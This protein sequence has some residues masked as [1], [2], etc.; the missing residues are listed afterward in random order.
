[1]SAHVVLFAFLLEPL[2]RP[3]L[4]HNFHY[5]NCNLK[6]LQSPMLLGHRHPATHPRTERAPAAEHEER[7]YQSNM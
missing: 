1:M 7:S 6:P 3:I 5:F 2:I 4:A